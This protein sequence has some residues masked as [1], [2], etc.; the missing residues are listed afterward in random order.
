MDIRTWNHVSKQVGAV[1]QFLWA[2]NI[3]AV[4]IHQQ[5]IRVCGNN[6]MSRQHMVKWRC[7]FQSDRNDVCNQ[8]HKNS[9]CPSSSTTEIDA[10]H[11]DEVIQAYHWITFAPNC[12]WVGIIQ[13]LVVNILQY[14]KMCARWV[15]HALS[16][17]HKPTQMVACLTFLQCFAKTGRTDYIVMG[18]RISTTSFPAAREL[19]QNGNMVP[20]Y[21]KGNSQ[22]HHLLE[23][24]WHLFAGM[25]LVDFIQCS[26]KTTAYRYSVTL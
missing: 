2:K 3:A 12:V 24:S 4:E 15:P 23:K 21:Q 16:V 9:G 17:D 18:Q 13:H 7:S 19:P 6:V 10:A 11:A 8:H 26:H 20:H 22:W 5:L 1:V 25:I 14:S